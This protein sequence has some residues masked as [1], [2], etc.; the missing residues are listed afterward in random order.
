MRYNSVY[1]VILTIAD[2]TQTKISLVAQAV[3]KVPA[4]RET[5][6]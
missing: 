1:H 4:V 6:V 2:Y 5:W 3:K